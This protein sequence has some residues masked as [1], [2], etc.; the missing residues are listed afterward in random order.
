VG[1]GLH[2]HILERLEHIAH[3]SIREFHGF[4]VPLSEE[5]P[6]SRANT[7]VHEASVKH[8]TA[9]PRLLTASLWSAKYNR[10]KHSCGKRIAWENT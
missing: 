7:H 10:C 5:R 9:L 6:L 3:A 2:Y 8:A 4:A 1:S